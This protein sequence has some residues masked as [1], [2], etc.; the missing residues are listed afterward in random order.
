MAAISFLTMY[1]VGY[2]LQIGLSIGVHTMD[3]K[4][5]TDEL[6]DRV[7]HE[8]LASELGVSIPTIRQARL[9]ESANAHRQPPEGWEKAVARLAEE[10]ARHYRELVRK[11]KG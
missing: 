3:F 10:R 1:A 11:L 2:T 9:D 5:A 4:N 7:T 8:T 6:F